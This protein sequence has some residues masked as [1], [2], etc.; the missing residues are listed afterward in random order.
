MTPDDVTAIRAHYSV[1]PGE[2]R[3]L[4]DALEAAWAERDAKFP[5]APILSAEYMRM[6]ERA[7]RAEAEKETAKAAL[8]SVLADW[9]REQQRAE[10]AEAEHLNQVRLSLKMDAA[11]ARVRAIIDHNGESRSGSA[12]T[13]DIRAAI[14]GDIPSWVRKVRAAI[15]GG[16]Q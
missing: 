4:C 15:E 5:G 13:S 14:E 3:A 9:M 10:R 7:E 2:C 1:S 16:E 12:L 8:A 11:L 6:Q